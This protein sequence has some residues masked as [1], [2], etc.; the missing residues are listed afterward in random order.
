MNVRVFLLFTICAATVTAHAQTPVQNALPMCRAQE[1]SLAT[2]QENGA[3]DGM[4][5]GGTLLVLR[6]QSDHAC[7]VAPF[8]QVTFADAARDLAT[9]SSVEGARGMHPGPVVAPIVVAAGAEITSK[10]RWTSGQVFEHNACIHPTKLMVRVED[11]TQTTPVQFRLCGDTTAGAPAY[12]M[13][14]WMV[15]PT[16]KP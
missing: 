9:A 7:R 14:R 2:D 1:L 8:P 6:N 13:T 11:G 16:F 4:S 12:T 3:F 5:H 10:L 15:D